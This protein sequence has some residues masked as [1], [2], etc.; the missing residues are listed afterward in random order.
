MLKLLKVSLNC[1]IASSEEPISHFRPFRSD[2]AECRRVYYPQ[3]IRSLMLTFFDHILGDTKSRVTKFS[4]RDF[5]KTPNLISLIFT[6]FVYTDER[7]APE[8]EWGLNV[9]FCVR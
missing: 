5:S 7:Y 9:S 6:R 1:A 8:V 2:H 3:I 4:D